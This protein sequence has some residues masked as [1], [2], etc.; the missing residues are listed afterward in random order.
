[1]FDSHNWTYAVL[2]QALNLFRFN[3]GKEELSTLS[4]GCSRSINVAVFELEVDELLRM[5]T[6]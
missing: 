1:M 2:D 3:H 5:K 6:L 4:N